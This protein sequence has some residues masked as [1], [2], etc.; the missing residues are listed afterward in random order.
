MGSIGVNVSVLCDI[1]NKLRF[2]G[3]APERGRFLSS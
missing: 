2:T 1:V 3:N